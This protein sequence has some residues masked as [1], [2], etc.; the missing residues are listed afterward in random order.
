MGWKKMQ[1]SLPK[2]QKELFIELTKEERIIVDI[3]QSQEQVQIDE[4]YFKSKLS[5]SEVAQALLMLEMQGVVSSLPG[6]I[7]KMNWKLKF[8]L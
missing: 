1:K 2:K 8:K 5:S 3:V 7:Y 6:K 4:L